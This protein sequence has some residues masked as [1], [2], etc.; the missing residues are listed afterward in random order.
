ML[1]AVVQAPVLGERL[2]LELDPGI[3]AADQLQ[4]AVDAD[5]KLIARRGEQPAM[6]LRVP[7]LELVGL[8]RA[9]GLLMRVRARFQ[10]GQARVLGRDRRSLRLHDQSY[11]HKVGRRNTGYALHNAGKLAGATVEKRAA[12]DLAFDRSVTRNRIDRPPHR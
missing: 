2:T 11:R 8:Q 1:L 6:K 7:V 5:Q 3:A 10:V 9:R 4:D 12:A